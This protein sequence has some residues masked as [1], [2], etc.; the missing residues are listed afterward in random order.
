MNRVKRQRFQDVYIGQQT[1]RNGAEWEQ[2]EWIIPSWWAGLLPKYFSSA[3]E[4]S[5]LLYASREEHTGVHSQKPLIGT[6][7]FLYTFT[8]EIISTLVY[9]SAHLLLPPSGYQEARTSIWTSFYCGRPLFMLAH[10]DKQFGFP[11]SQAEPFVTIYASAFSNVT[12][13]TMTF[14]NSSNKRK[15]TTGMLLLMS[16]NVF[17]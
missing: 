1:K 17:T 8:G 14:W 16:S 15:H 2:T 6:R 12:F 4:G 7:R 13:T 11:A 5:Q 3:V 9:Y 10:S